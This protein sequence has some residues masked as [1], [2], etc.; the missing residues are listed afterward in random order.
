MTDARGVSLAEILVA[1]CVLSVG[2]AAVATGLQ[3]ATRSVDTG[4]TETV[5]M[6][7]AEE[8]LERLRGVA[9]ADWR[10]AQLA[11]R[12]T[13]EDY[14]A[15]AGAPRFRRD[16]TVQDRGGAGCADAAPATV[17]CKTVRVAVSY[18]PAGGGERRTELATVLAP[19]P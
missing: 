16:T 10:D 11:P 1:T 6:L 18:R 13:R 7:L 3:Y 8:Q 17:T 12:V 9:L 4:R 15:I 19:R 5:A 2:L 14:G